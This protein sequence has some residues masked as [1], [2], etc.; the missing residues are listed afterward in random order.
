MRYLHLTPSHTTKANLVSSSQLIVNVDVAPVLEADDVRYKAQ[1]KAF[2]TEQTLRILLLPFRRKLRSIRNVLV[3]GYVD[4]DL[5]KVV[6]QEVA[7]HEF[8]DPVSTVELF[9]NLKKQG[10]K[11]WE[12][13][14]IRGAYQLWSDATSLLGRIHLSSSWSSLRTRGGASFAQKLADTYFSFDPGLIQ[15]LFNFYRSNMS[16]PKH[17]RQYGSLIAK[18]I[19]DAENAMDPKLWG[20]EDIWE[21]SDNHLAKL[22]YSQALL[23]RLV[24]GPA[25]LAALSCLEEAL[26]LVPNDAVFLQEQQANM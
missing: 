23:L 14:K 26:A 20:K 10:Q 4:P 13:G 3:L 18:C 16:D 11:Q 12:A 2:F 9:V 21:P 17:T 5:A 6:C 19:D 15:A 22:R 8:V 7:Q 1:L 24:R 25:Q